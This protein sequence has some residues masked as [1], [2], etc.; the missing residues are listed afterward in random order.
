MIIA[1]IEWKDRE[2][3]VPIT[4]GADFVE[5][6]D[7]WVRISYGQGNDEWIDADLISSV[8]T[9]PDDA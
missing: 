3:R 8:R 2:G 6:G 7:R 1:T 4:V 5:V 9:S